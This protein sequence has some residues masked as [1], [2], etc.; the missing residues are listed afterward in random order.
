MC[1]PPEEQPR[2]RTRWL[3]RRDLPAVLEIEQTCFDSPWLPSECGQC[4]QQRNC[5]GMVTEFEDKVV[6]YM[7]YELH[8]RRVHLLNFAVD[9]G[10]RRKG[11]ATQM[12]GKLVK[13]LSNHRR[14]RIVVEVRETN[15]RAQLFFRKSGFRAIDI[16]QGTYD[17]TSEDAYQMEY[18]VPS[19]MGVEKP[20]RNRIIYTV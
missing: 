18:R 7:I 17:D 8:K 13:K 12:I 15:L 3:I 6:G 9:E 11:I 20:P 5:V 10:F 16:L 19:A 1:R 4:L 2:I 14:T